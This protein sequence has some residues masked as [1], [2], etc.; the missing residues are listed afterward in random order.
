MPINYFYRGPGLRW[1][2]WLRC[3]PGPQ[4]MLLPRPRPEV[5]PADLAVCINSDVNVYTFVLLFSDTLYNAEWM[6]SVTV[7]PE[8]GKQRR[9]PLLGFIAHLLCFPAAFPFSIF[10]LSRA[11]ARGFWK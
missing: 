5:R 1:L 9:L 6:R 2:R 10:F 8:F 4:L 7:H 11:S 3:P